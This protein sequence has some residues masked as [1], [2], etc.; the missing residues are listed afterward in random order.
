M[1]Q[2]YKLTGK[3]GTSCVL[4]YYNGRL[5][6]IDFGEEQISSEYFIWVAKC[7]F[8][9]NE[10]LETAKKTQ[11][12]VSPYH[13]FVPSFEVFWEKYDYKFDK[14]RAEDRWNKLK[15][16]DK[17]AAID[18][19]ERYKNELRKTGVAQMYAKTYLINRVWK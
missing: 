18:Y 4:A 3:S 7:C 1:F 6:S 13:D 16:A 19:I 15:D 14:K 2:K 5:C 8:F 9:E 10:L 12:K 11:S 17:I